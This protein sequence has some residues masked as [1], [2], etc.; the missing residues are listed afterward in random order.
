MVA[1]FTAVSP[2]SALGDEIDKPKNF[3][4]NFS[5]SFLQIIV[6]I[7]EKYDLIPLFD[8]LEAKLALKNRK[9]KS[10]VVDPPLCYPLVSTIFFKNKVKTLFLSFILHNGYSLIVKWT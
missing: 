7:G 5:R 3:K 10:A 1:I 9:L 2:K 8:I 4:L 6:E